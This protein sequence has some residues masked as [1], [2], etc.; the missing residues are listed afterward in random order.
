MTLKTTI[1]A[2]VAATALAAPAAASAAGVGGITVKPEQRTGTAFAPAAFLDVVPKRGVPTLAGRLL[3]RNLERREL[4]VEL[5][6][7]D[8]L[9]A[10]NLGYAYTVSGVRARGRTGWIRLSVHRLVLAP[11]QKARV[12]VTALP[13]THARPGDYLAGISVEAVGQRHRPD[14]EARMAISR[15][16]RYVVGVQMRIPGPRS[17][18]LELSRG[19]VKGMPAGVTFL[20][21]ARNSGNVM[22]KDVHGDISIYRRGRRIATASVGPGTFVTGTSAKL[23]LLA[24][25][26]RPRAGTKYRLKARLHYK[27]ATARY[28]DTVVFG[29]RQ[30][31]AQE[32]YGRPS[33]SRGDGGVPLLLALALALAA[34]AVI[35]AI[36]LGRRRQQRTRVRLARLDALEQQLAGGSS[37]V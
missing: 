18:Q 27:G 30:E 20:V 2:L 31:R 26:E 32:S 12:A 3:I 9:T 24:A 28:D 10:S 35:A 8:A 22:L 23:Q 29:E 7:V 11:G 16:E 34:I 4:T 5:D 15:S 21:T 13:A 14:G 33:Q 17:A 25:T 1:A 19:A 6:A 37:D 36:V